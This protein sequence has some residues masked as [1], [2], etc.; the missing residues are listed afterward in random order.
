M[1]HQK[2]VFWILG[3]TSSGKT[4]IGKKLVKE[5]RVTNIPAIHY[6]GDEIRSFF[7]K[8]L[9]FK[10]QDRLRAVKICAHLAN[11]V[12]DAGLN[13]VVS[14]LTANDDARDYIAKN[15]PNL[16][17]IYLKCPI[18]ICVKRDS[19]GLYQS[20]KEGKIDP[21]TLIGLDEPYPPPSNPDLIISTNENTPE[22]SIKIVK[23][24]LTRM[25]YNIFLS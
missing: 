4:T 20:A 5:M 6:D 10:P 15:V 2:F 25:G 16:I 9:G 17:R 22:E 23:K 12:S 11:K 18:E 21:K 3:P 13:V 7:G 24:W 19:R 1:K 14:A 8:T